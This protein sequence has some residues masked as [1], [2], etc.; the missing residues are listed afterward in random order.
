MSKTYIPIE[1]RRR[2]ADVAH[3]RCGYCLT[4][5]SV[6][7][8]PMHVE[9]IIPEAMGGQSTEENLWLACPLCNGFKGTKTHAP[10]PET[11]ELVPLFNPRTREWH[12]HFA[13]NKD[14]TRILGKTPIGR[15]TISALQLNNE[16]IVPARRIWTIAGWH[17]PQD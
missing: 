6:V 9:H 12:E 8:M 2:V 7:G 10:D 11:N 13:W 4:S 16:F 5:Q 1:T 3:H 15:A 17:P 14:N